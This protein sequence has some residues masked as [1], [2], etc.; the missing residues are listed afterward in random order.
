MEVS[1]RVTKYGVMRLGVR[2]F[3]LLCVCLM[4]LGTSAQ[5]VTV[6][7]PTAVAV[8]QQFQLQY[9]INTTDVKSFHIGN[10]P[11]AFELVYGPSTSTQQSFSMVNGRTSQSASVTYTYVL[12]ANKNGTFVIPAAYAVIGG[13]KVASQALKIN[14]SGRA[15]GNARQGAMQGQ[16]SAQRVDRAGSRIS[17]NDLFIRVTANKKQVYEQEPIL[18][19]YKVYTQVELTQLEGKMPDLNGFHTQEIQLPQQK[20]FHVETINGKQYR[21]VTWSQ[22][23]MFPQMSGKLEIPSITFKG[24]V[25]QENPNVDPFEAFFNGGSGY[26]EVKKE[27]KAPGVTIQVNPLPTKPIGFSSG[28]GTFS[29]TSSVDKKTVKAGDPIRLRVVVNGTGNT[30]LIKMPEIQLPNDFDKYDPKITDNTKLSA[31]GVTGSMVYDYLIVPRNKGKYTIPAIDLI[32]F[33]TNSRTYKTSRTNAIEINVEKGD[34]TS[35]SVDYSVNDN[36]ISD[37]IVGDDVKE[38]PY[39]TFFGSVNSILLNAI[40]LVIFVALLIVFRK[41]AAAMAD[42]TSLKVK[43]ASGVATKRLKKAQRLMTDGKEIMFYEEVLRALWGYISD[44]LNIPVEKLS[45]ENILENL[46]QSQVDAAS[47]NKFVEAIDECEFARYAPKN[48]T[49]DIRSM[50]ADT[51]RKASEA[52]IEI[53]ESVKRHKTVNKSMSLL[54]TTILCICCSLSA[55]AASDKIQADEAYRSGDYQKAIELYIKELKVGESAALY[56]NLANCYYRT[57][58]IPKAI[59]NY[60]RA[61]KYAPMNDKIQHSMDIAIS[62]TQDRLPMN[63]DIFLVQWY[64]GLLSLMTIDGW[65]YMALVSLIVSLLLFLIFLFR[66]NA[67]IR[68]LSFYCSI[69]LFLIFVCGNIFAWQRKVYLTSHNSAV[70]MVKETKMKTSPTE[71]ATDEGAIHE[72]T[73]VIIEDRD[74]NGWYAV[75]LSDGRKGWVQVKDVEEI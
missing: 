43:K 61:Y 18:L 52:I 19:T 35:S 49:E 26:V 28:V 62:K 37:I 44:K 7:G 33:D 51:Y 70:V 20:T 15:Q 1:K 3:I 6:K 68:R 74:I 40:T 32:Y 72:G 45:R 64:K 66:D 8:G 17:G 13:H 41:R 14:V 5:K 73:M 39:D 47:T 53:E 60:G 71:N 2:V 75:S 54:I 50:M 12:S 46:T 22:Y 59:L 42:I 4:A 63:A 23:V 30:K 21:C 29:I 16:S 27:I 36:D 9:V 31:D 11:E 58:N 69:I 67:I 25:V 55:F 24:I 56:H 10:I 65:A 34:G 38:H 57:D 48:N